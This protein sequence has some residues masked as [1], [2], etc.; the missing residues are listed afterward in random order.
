MILEYNGSA[1]SIAADVF[2]APTATIIGNVM[3]GEGSSVW[4]GAVLRGDEGRIIIGRNTNIQDNAIIHSTADRPTVICDDVTI[5]NSAVLKGCTI[6]SGAVVGIG[7][8]V[9][10]YAMV[11]E[12]GMVE[13]GSV[14]LPGTKIPPLRFAAGSP[15][16][17]QKDLDGPE[18]RSV[19][20][21]SM[22]NRKLAQA[23]MELLRPRASTESCLAA[24]E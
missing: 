12:Q 20:V 5:G 18:L 15:A 3:I 4:F 1:P 2:V 17:D 8:I 9:L 6:E 13:A 10:E 16:V 24:K 14:V 22:I 23:Y 21:S 19:Q 7:A 11:G